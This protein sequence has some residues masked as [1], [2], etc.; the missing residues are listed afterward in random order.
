M[1]PLQSGSREANFRT[2]TNWRDTMKINFMAALFAGSIIG[3]GSTTLIEEADAAKKGCTHVSKSVV[4]SKK[5]G[6]WASVSA[7]Y[8]DRFQN[9]IDALEEE[10]AS[11]YYMGGI[12]AGKCAIPANKHPCGMA[13]D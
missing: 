10:G 9:Y 1:A 6:A 13:M 3:I 2:T 12:R 8:R 4:C 11:I 5:T 7:K